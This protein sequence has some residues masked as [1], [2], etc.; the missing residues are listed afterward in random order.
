V[1]FACHPTILG[2]DNLLIS[3][4]FPGA[5]RRHL[6]ASFAGPP[7]AP[8]VLFVNGA[9]GDVSTRFTRRA[10]N[11]EEVERIGASLAATAERALVNTTLIDAPIRHAQTSLSLPARPPGVVDPDSAACK[12][13]TE[14]PAH[15]SSASARI[16]ETRDQGAAMLSALTALS[17]AAVPT[18]LELDAWSI[19]SLAIVA[20][21]GELASTLGAQISSA[22]DVETLILGYTNGY[23]GYLPDRP[24]YV[25]R[26][27][28]GLA[29]PFGPE[30]GE[31]VVDAS[32]GLLQQL[33][34]DRES[35]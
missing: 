26:T 34:P 4:D 20:I 9:A 24:A 2:A 33:A 27:Y 7:D 14:V 18:M 19:G 35:G 32:I 31:R 28:E 3:A 8:L 11:V 10:Q 25:E 29:S 16:K 13:P 17:A 21:P 23:A 5:L 22:M 15:G 6:S 12:T 1:H 30:A